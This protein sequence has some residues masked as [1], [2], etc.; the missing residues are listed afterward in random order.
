MSLEKYKNMDS[1]LLYDLMHTKIEP[2]KEKLNSYLP[3]FFHYF[4]QIKW[5]LISDCDAQLDLEYGR[6]ISTDNIDVNFLSLVILYYFSVYPTNK[7]IRKSSDPYDFSSWVKKQFSKDFSGNE[8]I[9]ILELVIYLDII[10]D[11]VLSE[12]N[13]SFFSKHFIKIF[14]YILYKT[15]NAKGKIGGMD[16]L[17]KEITKLFS[18][19][20][21][22][23]KNASI[24]NPFAGLG[25]FGI[26]FNDNYFGQELNQNNTNLVKL[27]LLVHKR[28]KAK[29][30]QGNSIENWN[31]KNEKYD[32]IVA[33]P[34]FGVKGILNK[35]N[36]K[37]SME[38]FLL[39]NSLQSL[40]N[41]GKIIT[42]VSNNFLYSNKTLEKAFRKYLV[43]NDLIEMIISMPNNLLKHTG[44]P[45]AIIVINKNK[46]RSGKLTFV[47]ASNFTKNSMDQHSKILDY[48][49][50]I[51]T[52]NNKDFEIDKNIVS[53]PS[54][55]YGNNNSNIKNI[56]NVNIKKSS[57]DLNTLRYLLDIDDTSVKLDTVLEKIPN[58][59]LK[60]ISGNE[61]YIQIKNL[62][63][64]ALDY[65]LDLNNLD[66]LT[67]K[68]VSNSNKLTKDC[69]LI[70]K[71]GKNL[72][73]TYFKYQKES[74]YYIN[75]NIIAFS[76]DTNKI[77]V[78]YLI[79]ELHSK[80]LI[81]QVEAL[82]KGTT[83]PYLYLKDVKN[84]KIQIP[85]LKE[86]KEKVKR[87]KEVFIDTK[88]KE[89][90]L[91]KEILGL[92]DDS[93]KE[94]ASIKHTLRQYLNDLKSNVI[95]TRKFIL[96]NSDINITLDMPYSKQLD[97][98]F[99]NHLLSL[100]STIDSMSN[101]LTDF[102]AVKSDS[103]NEIIDLVSIINEAQNRTK[104]PELF[105]FEKLFTDVELLEHD[106][107]IKT[108][109]FPPLARFNKEDFYSI[110][111]NIVSNA[112]NHGFTEKKKKYT[113]RTS[114]KP[115]YEKKL[116]IIEIENNGNPI[117]ANFTF[118][119]LKIRGEKTTNSTGNGIGGND[120]YKLLKKHQSSFELLTDNNNEFTVKYQIKIPFV[121]AVLTL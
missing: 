92:K 21:K 76:I 22:L 17:P 81:K 98:S 55:I 36:E 35:N 93:F 109:A 96:K 59:S 20:V 88:K 39:K 114:I 105:V 43:D 94:F 11:D 40:N 121:E 110:F 6:K 107:D 120:I 18:N 89:L 58:I 47:N 77:D 38:Q 26:E 16:I 49:S 61:K 4:N 87:L 24:Y 103:L 112:I 68:K 102:D 27:R 2:D 19:L 29:I 82:S 83:I 52:I 44:L 67:T 91:Q 74:D 34:P 115:D 3:V 46:K 75:H 73:P 54:D 28:Y 84:L 14:E 72:K 106:T 117:P 30:V 66:F 33:N 78:D 97:I 111:S 90:E 25:S 9:E 1:E 8:N 23:P 56:S 101:I 62:K 71:V 108:Y 118:E 113:I 100:E 7:D 86:Q 64:D 85:S 116:W 99:K 45:F 41:N 63:N 15:S 12:I 119:R 53:E 50:L 69:L 10:V 32:L 57:Y 37:I 31:P 65:K 70:S 95:G 42:T 79:T 51:L 60:K 80:S 48:K 5:H 104:K 13:R